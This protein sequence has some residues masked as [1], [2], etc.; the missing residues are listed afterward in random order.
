MILAGILTSILNELHKL[1]GPLVYVVVCALVFGEAA[2]FIGF[3]LPAEASVIVGGAIASQGHMSIVG[4]CLGVV[5]SAIVGDSVG[6]FVGERWGHKL[7]NL[8]IVRNRQFLINS[9]LNGLR[10][11]GP[12]YVFIGRFT[13][14]LRAVM[15][16]LAGMSKMQYRKFLVANAAGGI[17]WG[18]SFTL[19][20]YYAGSALTKV[21][22]YAGWAGSALVVL[23]VGVVV[24]IHIFTKRRE[25]ALELSWREQ[26]PN[27]ESP[28]S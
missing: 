3:V 25:H 16:G 19:L 24:T 6:Y 12:I 26:H 20:G 7:L 18:V 11:R 27:E 2:L 5:V 9:A 14:F 28:H 1:P 13:A 22:K 4:L 15:P 10:K 23:V 17:V 21:E 8:P